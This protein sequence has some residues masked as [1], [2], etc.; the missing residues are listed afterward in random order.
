MLTAEAGAY[1]GVPFDQVHP[2]C[3]VRNSEH[4]MIHTA[5]AL[6]IP[7][8]ARAAR[9]SPA[10]ERHELLVVIEDLDVDDR[11]HLAGATDAGNRG[12]GIPDSRPQV[13]GAQVDGGHTAPH[14]HADSK[15]AGDV[16]ERR[17][18]AAVELPGTRAALELG[19][20]GH[21]DRDL[22]ALVVE[23]D[24]LEAEPADERRAVE[25]RLHFRARQ[26]ALRLL[27]HGFSSTFPK[28]LRSSSMANA[29]LA[30]SSGSSLSITGLIL[31]CRTSSTSSTSSSRSQP[32][33]PNTCSSKVQ[34]KRKSSLGSNPAVA[35][36]VSTLPCLC[37]TFRLGTQVSPPV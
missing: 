12:Q 22:L 13:I 32:L 27:A 19:P 4:Q 8:S 16:D 37:S 29:S 20:H 7:G 31:P 6:G 24:N 36:Q 34:M 25:N 1:A 14:Q 18:R 21:S 28:I 33:E 17:N 26:L 3:E 35:P 2:L 30:S 9:I 5:T 23:R 11:G 10:A 15:I